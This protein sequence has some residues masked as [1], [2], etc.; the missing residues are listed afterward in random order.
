[1]ERN[2]DAIV[3]ASGI[4]E[5][6]EYNL[7]CFV[8]FVI[9]FLPGTG[10]RDVNMLSSCIPALEMVMSSLQFSERDEKIVSLNRLVS[11]VEHQCL[12]KAPER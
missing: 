4:L 3:A 8:V 9:A 5:E 2:E 10:V 11:I 6:V 12:F 7:R 1:M